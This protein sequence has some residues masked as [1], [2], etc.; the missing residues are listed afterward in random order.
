MKL[1]FSGNKDTD[2]EIL[3]RLS[4]RDLSSASRLNK[5]F[6]YTLCDDNFF[7]NK[8]LRS[9]PDILKYYDKGYENYTRFYLMMIRYI[10]KLEKEFNYSYVKG[11]PEVQYRL[12]YHNRDPQSLLEKS[13]RAKEIE[14]VKESIKRGA[15]TN[16]YDN[17]ALKLATEIKDL[18]IFKC[19]FENGANS[20]SDNR[21]ILGKAIE[22]GSLE[23]VK[24]LVEYALPI[25]SDAGYLIQ[26]G[27]NIEPF[28]DI[29]LIRADIR[30]HDEVVNYFIERG[31]RIDE[32]GRQSVIFMDFTGV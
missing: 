5:Y 4:D 27:L 11:N 6:Y 10:F 3:F 21:N 14:L 7:Y 23:I 31:A 32:D 12:F 17:Y 30:G 28:N 9:Y 15:Y 2:R 8:L 25:A 13:I 18:E 1:T 26:R 22:N 24:Y 20:D 29:S 16:E 19:L